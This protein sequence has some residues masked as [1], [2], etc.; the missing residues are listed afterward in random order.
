MEKDPKEKTKKEVGNR[1]REIREYLDLSQDEF[2]LVCEK[3]PKYVSRME[4]GET[5]LRIS[6]IDEVIGNL[7]MTKPE[8]FDY[9][10][11][12]ESLKTCREKKLKKFYY[13]FKRPKK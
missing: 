9:G 3:K 5:D 2:A 12:P 11:I 10:K 8:F 4:I 7:D 1:F 6:T 13:L